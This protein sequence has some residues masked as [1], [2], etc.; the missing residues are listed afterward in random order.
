MKKINTTQPFHYWQSGLDY[1]YLIS[2]VELYTRDGEEFYKIQEV[3]K[4][5]AFLA[6][7][8]VTSP[9]PLRGMELRF[10]R[11]L[12]GMSQAALAGS[13]GRTRDVI[14]KAENKP[15]DKI[16]GQTDRLIR[17]IYASMK[18]NPDAC[19]K[20]IDLMDDIAENEFQLEMNLKFK[21]GWILNDNLAA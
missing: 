12:L 16:N 4:L 17:F 7:K 20:L 9:N 10:L 15:H 11:S 8:I 1:V 5:H 2:G 3:D 18:Q 13:V 21:N 6:D 14:V 19:K